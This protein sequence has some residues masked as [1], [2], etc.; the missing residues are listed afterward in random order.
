VNIT[1]F[2]HGQSNANFACLYDGALL[3]L[4]QAASYW[5]QGT[6]TPAEIA[7]GNSCVGG[8]GVYC[9]IG[10]FGSFLNYGGTTVTAASAAT[11]N[12]TGQAMIS[13]ITAES[14]TV[15]SE[16]QAIV[17][18]WGE[19][20]SDFAGGGN[21]N[22]NGSFGYTDKPS[23]KAA[24]L[25]DIG[26]IRTAFNKTAAQL[27]V[28]CFGPPFGTAQ[29]YA[30]VRE[31]WD[32]LEAD[33]TNNFLWGVRMTDDCITRGDNWNSATGVETAGQPIGGHVAAADNQNIFVRGGVALALQI[34]KSQG[35]NGPVPA[36]LGT[37][38]GP[39]ITAAS[40]SGTTL[41]VTIAHD[42]GN[43]LE[44]PLLA[45]QGVGWYLMD[46][47]SVGSPGNIIGATACTRVDATHLSVTLASAPVNTHNSCRLFYPWY[48]EVSSYQSNAGA[49]MSSIVRGNAVT[50]NYATVLASL[51]VNSGVVIPQFGANM[52]LCTPVTRT[53]S[54]ASAST[55]FGIALSG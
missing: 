21:F 4:A 35:L 10:G 3:M 54:G 44:L 9:G 46:G 53:G 37:G 25:N 17:I 30:M 16:T 7:T 38:R 36:A 8:T 15:R 26:Q 6:G 13:S 34:E 49:Y 39:Q 5:L 45:A 2:G 55:T 31:A 42:A 43:D 19:T 24:L 11:Y 12:S 32:E 29:G 47:G 48:G 22:N 40:L 1:L 41:T 50:D 52:P 33:T 28:F 27:P 20:D 14:A 23:Y 18:Y 51:G